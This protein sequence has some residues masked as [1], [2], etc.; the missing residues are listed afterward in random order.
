MSF[1]SVVI[2][3]ACLV[4]MGSFLLVAFNVNDMVEE[5]E[6]RNQIMA[7]VDEELSEEDARAIESDILTLANVEGATFISQSEAWGSWVY[8]DPD[9]FA[10]LDETTLRHRFIVDLEDIAEMEMTIARLEQVPGIDDVE[11]DT[12]IAEF[13]VTL[14]NVIATVFVVIIGVLLAIS[15]FIISNTIKLATFD[16][17]EEIAIM[18]MVG[19]TKWFIRWPF[20][21][22]GFI[23]GLVGATI[24]FFLQWGLY[25]VLTDQILVLSGG[26]LIQ[27]ASFGEV[28]DYLLYLFLGTGFIVGILGSALTIRKYLKV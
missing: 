10:G 21:F 15:I 25:G 23:L 5:A 24:A 3:V 19:A 27:V 4:I 22:Q 6:S 2:I 13:F 8:E 9:R 28:A 7:F 20:I 11:A 18:R 12:D 14:R 16:R 26:E 17:R 1:A